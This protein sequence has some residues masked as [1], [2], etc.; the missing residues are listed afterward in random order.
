MAKSLPK[1]Y[2]TL[3]EKKATDEAYSAWLKRRAQ[4][5]TLTTL[6]LSKKGISFGNRKRK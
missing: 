1:S 2:I 5:G 6:N 3:L 4:S